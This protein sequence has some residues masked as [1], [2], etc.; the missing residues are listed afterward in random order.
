MDFLV[1]KRTG[2]I[3]INEINTL[4]GFTNISMFPLLFMEKGMKYDEII[5][6][7]IRLGIE[8]FMEKDA[9]I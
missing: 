4:P 7:I 8:K 2:R 5:E 6:E 9:R 3:F 1:E